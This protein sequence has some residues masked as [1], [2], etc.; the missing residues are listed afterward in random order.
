MDKSQ[1]FYRTVVFTRRKD[2]EIA[3]T[4][5]YN[6]AEI[7]PLEPW[8]GTV[9]SL[10]DGEHTIEELSNYLA[11][12]Y[13]AGPPIDFEKTLKSVFERLIDSGFI[14]LSEI[15]VSLPYYLAEPIEKL[16]LD[17]AIRLMQADG[18]RQH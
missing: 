6:P 17:K 1:Y 14:K 3:L 10:A 11:G 7:T 16:D 12:R 5:I 15:K 8:L 9:V 13:P 2:N 18:H 4:N